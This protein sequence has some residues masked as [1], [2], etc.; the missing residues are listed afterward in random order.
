MDNAGT[1]YSSEQGLVGFYKGFIG[2][3]TAFSGFQK[4]VA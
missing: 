1:L 3:L 2:F 4:D